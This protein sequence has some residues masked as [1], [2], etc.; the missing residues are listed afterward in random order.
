[1]N[2]KEQKIKRAFTLSEVMVSIFIFS[3]IIVTAT[4]LFISVIK[5]QTQVLSSQQIIRELSYVMEYM[6]RAIRMALKDDIDGVDCLTGDKV[7]YEAI[8]FGVRFRNYKNECQEFRLENHRLKEIKVVSGVTTSEAF[9][10][11]PDIFVEKF[12]IY[13]SGEDQ[14]PADYSQP[15][16]TLFLE[17]KKKGTSNSKMRIQTTISQRN[18]DFER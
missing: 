7:N 13:I 18:L 12:N 4:S 11:S 6:S 15:K 3:I 9:L 8:P 17:V 16:I 1:M 14:P 10:T 2:K 5:T